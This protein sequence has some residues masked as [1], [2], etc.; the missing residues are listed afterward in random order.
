MINKINITVVTKNIFD[1]DN[2]SL[3]CS[4]QNPEKSVKEVENMCKKL[5][6][7]KCSCTVMI[8]KNSRVLF[9]YNYLHRI[10]LVLGG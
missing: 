4:F 3:N 1:N 7:D 5:N 9:S 6:G 10:D 8:G 2:F